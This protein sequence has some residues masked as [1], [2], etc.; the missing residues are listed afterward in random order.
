VLAVW[1]GLSLNGDI[2]PADK[3]QPFIDDALDQI[4]FIR[5]A[6]DSKWGA[7]RAALGHPEPFKLHFV[8]VGNEDWLAGGAAGWKSYQDYRFPRFLEAINK[9]YPDIQVIASG[10]TSD[11]YTPPAPA[12]GDYHPYREP[13]SL[14]EEFDR[15]DNDMGHLVGEPLRPCVVFRLNLF[16]LIC[17]CRGGCRYSPQWRYRLG[18]PSCQVS[19]VDWHCRRGHFHDW[20]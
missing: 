13:D 20:I 1:G 14:V 16:L 12:I 11:G 19:L 15:F 2:T 10:A 9:A 17:S 6:A 8:E 18:W 3:L 5:G 7:K 4:E